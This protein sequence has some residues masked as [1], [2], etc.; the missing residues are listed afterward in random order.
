MILAAGVGSRLR[1]LTDKT[2]KALLKFKG[3]TMLEHVIDQLG[4]Y[5]ISE[6]IVNLHHHADMVEDYV[7]ENRNFG[8]KIAFS[9]ERER[10]MDTGGGIMKAR[11]F[12]DGAPFIVHN[13]DVRTDLDLA[14]L[15]QAHMK[16]RPLATLAVSDRETSRNLLVDEGGQLCGWRNNKTGEEIITRVK[17]GMKPVAF[18]AVH[19]IEPAIFELLDHE[20][21]FSM[22]DAYL[23]L[24]AENE[25]MTYDHSGGAWTDMASPGNFNL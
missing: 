3:K 12:L 11:W 22:T 19:V 14:G 7:V 15:Y 2:P 21:P 10:L 4:N 18:S 5:G 23:S 16:T 1:P 13:V 24:A 17:K 6:I 8:M 25:I 9:S 20:K